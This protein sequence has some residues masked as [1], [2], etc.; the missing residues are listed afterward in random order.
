MMCFTTHRDHR[1]DPG[2]RTGI[3][4]AL[5]E[6]PVV[7]QLLANL[8]EC[9]GQLRELVQ[10]RLKLLLVVGACVTSAATTSRLPAATTACAL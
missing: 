7:R 2:R 1:I 5:A 4:V 3:H 10:H 6:I 9:L 8:A